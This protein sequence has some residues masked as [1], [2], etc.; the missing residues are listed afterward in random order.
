MLK[1]DKTQGKSINRI[2]Q[3]R[4]NHPTETK[5]FLWY[6]KTEEQ[7]PCLDGLALDGVRVQRFPLGSLRR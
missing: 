3:E 7:A 6:K 2:K 1:E 5:Q 4:L